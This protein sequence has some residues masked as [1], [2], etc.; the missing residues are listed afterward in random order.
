MEKKESKT[1]LRMPV[2]VLVF[3]VYWGGA[4]FAHAPLFMLAPEAPGKGAFDLHTTVTHSRQGGDRHSEL[5]QEFTYGITRDLAAGFSVP[6]T[7][8]ELTPA[9]GTQTSSSG[10]DNP[11]FFG[12]WRFWDRD[13]LG[14]KYSAALRL[15][16]T[17]PVGDRSIARKKPDLMAGAAYGMESLKWYYLADVRY[18]HH[19]DDG[20]CKPGDRFFADIAVGLRPRLGT[21]EETD[22]VFFLELNYMDERH[23]RA[24]GVKIPDTGGSFIS[25]SPEILI[26]PTN[27]IMIRGGVQIP[28]YQ[29]LNGVREPKDFTLK[30][31]IETRY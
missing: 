21:L 11:R 31:V 29:E 12:Q 10:I 14:A 5:E 6:L 27:R 2:T 18:L 30:I 9:G 23:A 28:I 7:R 24:G 26:S 20:G 22:I 15:A 8:E 1:A 16:S 4:A 25:L 19:V 3:L 13:V 17:V